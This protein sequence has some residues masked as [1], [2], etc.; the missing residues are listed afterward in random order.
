VSAVGAIN[1]LPLMGEVWGKRITLYDRPLP[2]TLTELPDIQYR[3]VA[4][5]YF[6]AL[7]I[8]IVA[9]RAFTEADTEPA[10]KVAI[11]NRALARQHWPDRDPIGKQISVNPPVHLLS[12][13][14]VPP[15][16]EPTLLTI[17]GVAGDV[18]YGALSAAAIPLVYTPY[19][20]GSEGAT[21]MFLVV[22]ASGDASALMPPIRDRISRLDPDV[23]AS[24]VQTMEARA[25]ASLAAPR[26]HTRVLGAFAGLALLLAA[27]GIYGV[28]SY[29]ARQRTREIG[30]R[31]AM[32]AGAPAILA[33]LLR[34]GVALVAIGVVTGLVG[35][36][37]L[38]RSLQALLFEVSATDPLVFAAITIA[39]VT[40]ALAAAW[41]P[42]RRATR[43]DPL[44]A[45]RE[46]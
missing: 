10:A 24:N 13:G 17:V 35:A 27:T 34:Q 38:T 12:P 8:P 43:L 25:A 30:I 22:R 44:A 41:F 7:G 21:S 28:M 20:Q 31:M 40:V 1:A 36:A 46:D 6:R 37:A 4:G 26:L 23:A 3:V 11:V 32:G 5:D 45:L 39:L 9:G 16:Y 29:T 33:L 42:A 18:R 15:D 14:S 19:A 2:A